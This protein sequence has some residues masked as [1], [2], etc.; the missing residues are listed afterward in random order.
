[1]TGKVLFEDRPAVGALV[2]FHPEAPA[3]KATLVPQGEVDANGVFHLTTYTF[4]D[5]APPGRYRVTVFW[6]VP[7]KG[8]DG[9]DRILVPARYL[10]PETSGLTAVVLERATDLEPFKLGR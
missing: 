10:K 1:V 8:G 6:G 3:D 9:H 2:Q 4:G 7:A 5:A